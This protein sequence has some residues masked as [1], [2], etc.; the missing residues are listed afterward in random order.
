[1]LL[2][3]V[4]RLTPG[5][6]DALEG[7]AMLLASVMLFWVSYWIISKAE[8]DRW[9]QYIKGKVHR[10][11][12]AGSGTA[13][14]A[15]AFL[16]VYREGFETVL[17]YQ[18]LF[19][20]A[21][22]GDVM[23]P[24]GFA[25]GAVLLAIVYVVFSRFGVRIPIRQFFLVSGGLLYAMSVAFAGRG[26]HELQEADIIGM[27]PVAWAPHIELLGVFPTVETLLA[28]SVLLAL[29][30]FGIVLTV[31]RRSHESEGLAALGT[32]VGRLRGLAE[33]LREEV[34]A[35][36]GDAAG[37]V[38]ARLDGLIDEVRALE[39]RVVPRNGRA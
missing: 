11:V 16:A 1:V 32:E 19:A 4:F 28:Q 31:R 18:G 35:T 6:G 8:A 7:G 17:F 39:K 13:L 38:G 21:P 25:L 5:L 15:T 33:A 34:S 24:A 10:A 37:A 2:A 23:I 27:T 29:L 12:A 3:T 9:Q 36:R 14:F 22:A 30:V 20:S 26:V